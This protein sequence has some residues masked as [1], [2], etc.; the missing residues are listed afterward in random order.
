MST[1]S[2]HIGYFHCLAPGGGGAGNEFL[3]R[4]SAGLFLWKV[5]RKLLSMLH[6]LPQ[7]IDVSRQVQLKIK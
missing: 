2:H 1:V 6:V 4:V 3:P 5:F 7:L